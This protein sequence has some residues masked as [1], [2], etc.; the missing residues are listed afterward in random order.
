MKRI[1]S[2]LIIMLSMSMLFGCS[3]GNDY[4]E[5]VDFAFK[6]FEASQGEKILHYKVEEYKSVNF[7][8]DGE[9]ERFDEGTVYRIITYQVGGSNVYERIYFVGDLDG[10]K[11]LYRYYDEG[12]YSK[13]TRL[14][15]E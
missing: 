5:Y 8:V 10:A 12:T 15:T 14:T 3:K 7:N 2:I 13:L 1:C 11:V 6:Y 4:D 9:D